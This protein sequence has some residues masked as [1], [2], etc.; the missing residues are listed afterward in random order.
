MKKYFYCA[1]SVALLLLAGC[2][3]R[4]VAP[5]PQDPSMLALNQVA[6]QAETTLQVI[7]QAQNTEALSKITPGGL[8]RDALAQTATPTGW[9][10]PISVHY[11]GAAYPLIKLL[12]KR[13]G[14]HSFINGVLP[15]EPPLVTI[16]VE[17]APLMVVLRNVM[18]QLPRNISVNMFPSTNSVVLNVNG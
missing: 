15:A 12:S 14:Y 18:A 9:E 2:A 10:R 16:S 4:P 11:E 6:S 5:T 7:A 3:T 1:G 17:H 13:A 8:D